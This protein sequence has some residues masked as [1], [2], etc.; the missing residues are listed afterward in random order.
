MDLVEKS[1]QLP[2]SLERAFALFTDRI[3]DWWPPAR[4]HS[5]HPESVI[6]LSADRFWEF[7]PDGDE[8]E[9]GRVRAWEPPNRIVLEWFPGTDPEHPTLVEVDFISVKEGTEVRIT[10]RATAQSL[11]LF[12]LRAPRYAASWDLVL[13]AL[14]AAEP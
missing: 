8:V 7:A 13:A 14:L 3:D 1:V 6:A 12:P 9:L 5:K 2:C 11:E 10:H 4:R